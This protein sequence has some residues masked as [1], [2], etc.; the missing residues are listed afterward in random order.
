MHTMQGGWPVEHRLPDGR[1][2]MI[3][4]GF[5]TFSPFESPFRRPDPGERM[6]QYHGQWLS[7]ALRRGGD[8]PRIPVRAV[9]DGGY[10]SLL[11]TAGGRARAERWWAAALEQVPI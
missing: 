8:F 5:H 9:R 2:R 1:T 6:V 3:G 10:S 11:S 7:R 4:M